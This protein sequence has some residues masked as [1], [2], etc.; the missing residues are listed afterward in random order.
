MNMPIQ[1]ELPENLLTKAQ[2]LVHAG[3]ANDLNDLLA[4]ALRRYL[5]S[6]S[7]LLADNFIQ[8]DVQWGLFGSD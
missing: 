6:H 4:D 2:E 8:E 7:V 1:A 5:E 3:W